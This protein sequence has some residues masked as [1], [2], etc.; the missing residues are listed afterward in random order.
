[1]NFERNFLHSDSFADNFKIKYSF[2]IETVNGRRN[3]SY[4]L[5]QEIN[6]LHVLYH[7]LCQFD[8]CC[9]ELRAC[10]ILNQNTLLEILRLNLSNVTIRIFSSFTPCFHVYA[11]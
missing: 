7:K 10:K 2:R 4:R 3:N 5:F 9:N 1:M 11:C 8:K 6:L